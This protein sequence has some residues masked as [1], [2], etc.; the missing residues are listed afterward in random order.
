MGWETIFGNIA[1]VETVI[2]TMVGT[3]GTLTYQKCV[4]DADTL[5]EDCRTALEGV[6][7][8]LDEIPPERQEKI[9]AAAE[10]DV[11]K[12]LDKIREDLLRSAAPS[13][14]LSMSL[15]DLIRLAFLMIVAS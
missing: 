5:L 11:C 14:I 7:A 2:A 12:S 6:K 9:R 1:N 4:K 15:R 8:R 13:N 10:R 3:A